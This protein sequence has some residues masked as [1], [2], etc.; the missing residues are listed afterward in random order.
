MPDKG[1]WQRSPATD[2]KKPVNN[3]LACDS[4][5]SF[6]LIKPCCFRCQSI[7]KGKKI[8]ESAVLMSLFHIF[9][10]IFPATRSATKRQLS[11]QQT[12][13]IRQSTP[14]AVP[15]D[16]LLPRSIPQIHLCCRAVRCRKVSVPSH[17][18]DHILQT[19]VD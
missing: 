17:A 4:Y 9:T 14:L 8:T 6:F 11:L 7:I 12:M 3:R 1:Y 2:L 5:F 10:P 15:A 18:A 13:C 16:G 19:S